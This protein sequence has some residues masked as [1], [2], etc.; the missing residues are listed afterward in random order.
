MDRR[1][2]EELVKTHHRG[3]YSYARRVLGD[4]ERALEAT[5]ETF[6]RA[7]RYKD[8]FDPEKGSV[9]AWLFAIAANRIREERKTR[10]A[11]P[12]SLEEPGAVAATSEEGLEA[13]ARGAL[14][15]E[16]AR[17]LE[18]LP[19][20]YREV[21]V[22]KNVSDLSFEEVARALGL[23]VSAAKI[24]RSV[25]ETSSPGGSPASSKALVRRHDPPLDRRAPSPRRGPALGG[26]RPRRDLRALPRAR[27]AR[28]PRGARPP[29]RD[30]RRAAA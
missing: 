18:S 12:V 7:F 21:M 15:E 5:Q 30:P 24:A 4:E 17:A 16:V 6:V 3:V 22:L 9:R 29:R 10:S 13:F 26:G 11:E 2:F 1:A 14:R 8:S 23:S 28:S 25:G 19:P 27:R 20:D